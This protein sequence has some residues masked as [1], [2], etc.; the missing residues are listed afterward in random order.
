MSTGV[1]THLYSCLIYSNL[2]NEIHDSNIKLSVTT[3]NNQQ[4]HNSLLNLDSLI[5]T[6]YQKTLYDVDTAHQEFLRNNKQPN[7]VNTMAKMVDIIIIL[8]IFS[9]CN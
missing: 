6:T 5:H 7:K 9:D 2:E 8:L 3:E 1:Y 4:L